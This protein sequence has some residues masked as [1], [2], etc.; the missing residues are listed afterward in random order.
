[1]YCLEASSGAKVWSFQ[2]E[3]VSE[4]SPAISPKGEFIYVGSSD[5]QVYC[6]QASSGTKVWSFETGDKVY[7]S[8]AISANGEFIYVGAQDNHLYCL[9]ASSGAKVWSFET[10]FGVDSPTISPNGEFIY[11]VSFNVSYALYP[12]Q[13]LGKTFKVNKHSQTYSCSPC[14]SCPAGKHTQGCGQGAGEC[15]DCAD[16]TFATVDGGVRVSGCSKC[17]TCTNGSVA[18]GCSRTSPGSCYSFTSAGSTLGRMG[19]CCAAL[20]S[21]QSLLLLTL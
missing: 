17:P 5:N 15:V 13:L 9:E 20:L 16:G 1:M 4:S 7:S 14:T 21:I 3:D 18:P 6:L 2:T 11:V 10:E 8:P 19:W 12:A